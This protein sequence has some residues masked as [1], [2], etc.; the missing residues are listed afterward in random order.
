MV[1]TCVPPPEGLLAGFSL[2][3]GKCA[4]VL[5]ASEPF[6]SRDE[7]R[8]IVFWW[9]QGGGD[10]SRKDRKSLGGIRT[11]EKRGCLSGLPRVPRFRYGYHT[12]RSWR[13]SPLRPAT[14]RKHLPLS[15]GKT[16]PRC[17][18]GKNFPV[19]FHRI[20]TYCFTDYY[21]LIDYLYGNLISNRYEESLVAD[22]GCR[23]DG[24]LVWGEA[25]DSQF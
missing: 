7:T 1:R 3:G 17:F 15:S 12:S 6:H 19:F 4:R 13:A 9:W 11:D 18:I 24:C 5:P 22:A 20:K 23:T 16:F 21:Q 8:D 14:A 10:C 25:G 2:G